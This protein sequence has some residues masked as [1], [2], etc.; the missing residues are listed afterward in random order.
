VTLA[1]GYAARLADIVTIHLNTIAE[2][3]GAGV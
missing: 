2:L 1:G 3:Q